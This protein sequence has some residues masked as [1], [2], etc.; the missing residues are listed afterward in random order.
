[1]YCATI[2]FKRLTL[3]DWMMMEKES[4]PLQEHTLTMANEDYLEAIYVIGF[5]QNVNE[6][7]SVDIAEYLG[8][9]KA[10][11]SKALNTL[12]DEGFVHQSRYAKAS[13]TPE[14]KT[15]AQSL[16]KCHR[17]L[18]KF[19]IEELKV[20]EERANKEACLMEHVISYE[21]MVAWTK[22]L[23]KIEAEKQ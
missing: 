1:M 19:L 14:G 22:Y 16:W 15:Y 23:E 2:S 21:T 12:R 5:E 17:M 6:V 8:V 18:R 13:L 7:R 11:V 9:S 4:L 10:S 3:N 20:D